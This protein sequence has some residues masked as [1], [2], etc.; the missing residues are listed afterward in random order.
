[1]NSSKQN[2]P[3]IACKSLALR[4]LH[5]TN[6]FEEENEKYVKLEQPTYKQLRLEFTRKSKK[7]LTDGEKTQNIRRKRRKHSKSNVVN[8]REENKENQSVQKKKSVES[9]LQEWHDDEVEI[10]DYRSSDD[11]QDEQLEAWYKDLKNN[12]ARDTNL[13]PVN[14]KIEN[15][16]PVIRHESSEEGMEF[17][18]D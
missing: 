3:Q 7:T 2:P 9:F 15:V 6:S 14:S 12:K 5:E 17:M 18:N 16:G 10:A 1:M 8:M 13:P 4:L 11:S